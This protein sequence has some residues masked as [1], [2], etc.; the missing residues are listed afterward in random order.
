[1]VTPISSKC[2][3][4]IFT[5]FFAA[6]FCCYS[7]NAEE[8][9]GQIAAKAL[10]CFNNKFIYIS[11]EDA[12]RLDQN[13]NINVPYQATDGFCNGPCLAET[14]SLL[15][16]IDNIVS[17]FLFYNNAGVRDIRDTLHGGCSYT[18]QRGNFNVGDY[19]QSETSNSDGL[20]NPIK[21]Y[22]LVVFMVGWFLL[23]V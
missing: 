19:I 5:L 21:F 16:C 8:D 12:Y 20:L 13:G 18:S 7:G 11:C 9:P 22:A 10:L 14:Q 17:H 4:F 23:M 1:M 3:Y 2:K 6:V 15:N